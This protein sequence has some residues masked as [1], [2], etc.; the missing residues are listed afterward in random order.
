MHPHHHRRALAARVAFHQRYMLP[1]I[2]DVAVTDGA[3]IAE[4]AG[5]FGLRFAHHK[6][7]VLEPVA[8]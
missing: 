1:A 7:F 5:D 6:P 3:E 2:K 4:L 8:D